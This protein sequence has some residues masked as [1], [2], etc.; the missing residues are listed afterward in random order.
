MSLEFDPRVDAHKTADFVMEAAT[1]DMFEIA[2][3]KLAVDRADA[4][5]KA[6]AQKMITDHEKTT[7]GWV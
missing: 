5:T 4:K 6:F 2:S 7:W 3:S 1:S